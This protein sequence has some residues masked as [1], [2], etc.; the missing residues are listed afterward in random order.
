MTWTRLSDDFSDD[1][2]TLSDAAFR[3]HVEGLVWSNR[4]LLDCRIPKDDLRRFAKHP[5]AIEELLATGF[6]QDAGS[7][8]LIRHHGMYQR[9]REQAVAIQER[10]QT[11]GAKGGRP[12]GS[13]S[14]PKGP[15]RE[16]W[17]ETQMGS[18]MGSQME[19]QGD[20]TGRDRTGSNATTNSER[21]DPTTG[22]VPIEVPIDGKPGR[23]GKC[24][25]PMTALNP[26][27][28]DAAAHASA[29]KAM[30]SWG[31]R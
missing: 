20:G 29:H 12:K 14:K 21:V 3:L 16:R 22:E 19:T 2:W 27:C 5:E 8:Y 25:Y 13:K 24:P 28:P 10:N 6:W 31:D 30:A 9:S 4:K 17:P 15:P 26:G 18:D 23:C 11:N 7:H 1:C